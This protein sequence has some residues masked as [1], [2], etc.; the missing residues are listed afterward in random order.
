M[1]VKITKKKSILHK[2]CVKLSLTPW[3]FETCIS[4]QFRSRSRLSLIT[5]TQ[6]MAELEEVINRKVVAL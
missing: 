5:L 6:Q 4:A 1:G 3:I 2:I